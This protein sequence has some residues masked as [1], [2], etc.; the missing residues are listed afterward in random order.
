MIDSNALNSIRKLNR[1]NLTSPNGTSKEK[2]H[3]SALE[4]MRGRVELVFMVVL[5]SCMHVHKTDMQVC[6]GRCKVCTPGHVSSQTI[7]V[8]TADL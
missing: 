4:P 8:L 5:D 3:G 6:Q 1:A 7:S 2:S